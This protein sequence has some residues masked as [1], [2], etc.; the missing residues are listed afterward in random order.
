MCVCV[1]ACV[2]ACIHTYIH[3]QYIFLYNV[4]DNQILRVNVR[5]DYLIPSPYD[6]ENIS[7]VVFCDRTRNGPLNEVSTGY[8][9]SRLVQQYQTLCMHLMFLLPMSI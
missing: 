5:L 2:C 7:I 6:T 8:S 3:T 4:R 1:C 9:T